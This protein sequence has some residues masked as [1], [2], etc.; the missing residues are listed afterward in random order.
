MSRVFITAAAVTAVILAVILVAS[1]D[2]QSG[3]EQVAVAPPAPPEQGAP[4]EVPPAAQPAASPAFAAVV[5]IAPRS[6]PIHAD[7]PA[8]VCV[9][10]SE[11]AGRIAGIQMNLSWDDRCL[12]P[13]DPKQLCKA[14][15]ASGKSTQTALQSPSELK[16]IVISFTD[17][18]PIPD[19]EL[20]C[21]Q[22]VGKQRDDS[23]RVE[24][25]K[26]IGSTARGERVDGIKA[27]EGRLAVADAAAQQ[28]GAAPQV[29]DDGCAIRSHAGGSD[30]GALAVVAVGL[31]LAG[32]RNRIRRLARR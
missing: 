25:S 23:C 12:A 30:S 6:T 9:V 24:I 4:A 27:E 18:S 16:A 11:G 8:D 10:M 22:F 5:A 14:S 13:A 17:V 3:T 28:G 26:V 15:P 32:G 31:I 19:G 2:R 21:C 1:R 7:A 20:F 29:K